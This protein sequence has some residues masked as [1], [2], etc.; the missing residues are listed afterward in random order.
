MIETKSDFNENVENEFFEGQPADRVKQQQD[1]LASKDWYWSKIS[2]AQANDLLHGKKDGTFLVRVS[3]NANHDYTLTVKKDGINKMMRIVCKNGK[4][5]FGEPCRF[6]SLQ[7]LIEYHTK[8]S[9]AE[10]YPEMNIKLEYSL[11]KADI[12]SS[13]NVDSGKVDV[14]SL[15]EKFEL[16]NQQ[17]IDLT[18]E[19]DDHHQA[20][21]RCQDEIQK[22]K[23]SLN[24]FEET[25]AIFEEQIK[26]NEENQ[27]EAMQHEK[28]GLAKHRV[29]I[30]E[31]LEIKEFRKQL[32]KQC[33][34]KNVQSAAL[35]RQINE[36][37]PLLNEKK[38]I[39][40]QIRAILINKLGKKDAEKMFKCPTNLIYPNASPLTP[41]TPQGKRTEQFDG[42][43]D[44]PQGKSLNYCLIDIANAS[45]PHSTVNSPGPVSSP[46]S[47]NPDRFPDTPVNSLG[48]NFPTNPPPS[49][50]LTDSSIGKLHAGSSQSASLSP[51]GKPLSSPVYQQSR[52]VTADQAASPIP[53]P[54]LTPEDPATYLDLD[55]MMKTT[56]STPAIDAPYY[57][58]DM[59]KEDVYEIMRDQPDGSFLIRDSKNKPD[60]PFTLT[61]RVNGSTKLLRIIQSKVGRYGF[62]LDESFGSV[63]ELIEHYLTEPLVINQELTI[64][65]A[66]PMTRDRISVFSPKIS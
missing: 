48:N 57:V 66:Q 31:K 36:L 38:R 63:V 3:S 50:S 28:A 19:Y 64:H 23:Q 45:T 15:K 2:R 17:Y 16:E 29:D 52:S 60:S 59:S 26:L 40:E 41:I 25:F 27:K 8:H 53:P 30:E 11:S 35:D 51:A 32:E 1:Y 46:S 56:G 55:L 61:V 42:Q 5:G 49:T 62:K 33:E 18:Q 43:Y 9:L 14:E 7:S 4:Y 20:Y 12:C 24:C 21:R 58:G 65:L 37:K 13:L 22:F 34:E 39:T 47:A 44:H 6:D 54:P 10:Y